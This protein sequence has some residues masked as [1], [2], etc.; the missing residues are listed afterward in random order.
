MEKFMAAYWRYSMALIVE[1]GTGRSDAEALCSVAFADTY[2]TK[3]GNSAW[4]ALSTNEKEIALR[5]GAQYIT[6]KWR[7]RLKG[8]RVL[9]AQALDFPRYDVI[10]PDGFYV[11]ATS[12]PPAIAIVNAELGL[13]AATEDI[14]PS[15][16]TPGQVTEYAVQVGP[17]KEMTK[18]TGGGRST[19]TKYTRAEKLMAPFLQPGGR[20]YRS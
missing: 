12:V 5:K 3:M 10:D 6:A 18:Y 15:V 2:H 1:D 17:I 16:T 4:T 7:A 13:A 11:D 8:Y 19:D 14:M 20:L 9:Q